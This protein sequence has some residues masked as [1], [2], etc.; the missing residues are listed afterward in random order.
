[1]YNS[2]ELPAAAFLTASA[3]YRSTFVVVQFLCTVHLY[4]L[5]KS[6]KYEHCFNASLS[7]YD[8]DYECGVIKTYFQ[9]SGVRIP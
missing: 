1:M 7:M 8:P 3:F 9:Y 6:S 2:S 4:I 5:R